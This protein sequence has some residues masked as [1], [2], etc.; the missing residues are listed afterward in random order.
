MPHGKREVLGEIENLDLLNRTKLSLPKHF[1]KLILTYQRHVGINFFL[2]KP[3]PFSHPKRVVRIKLNPI[4]VFCR[5]YFK[6]VKNVA[7][8]GVMAVYQNNISLIFLLLHTI[9]TIFVD[10]SL[11]SAT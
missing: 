4:L 8:Y 2:A 3:K 11:A 10:Q 1:T 6:F 9:R 5:K 7:I